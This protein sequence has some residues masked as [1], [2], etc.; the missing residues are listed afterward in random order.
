ML[1]WAILHRIERLFRFRIIYLFYII[2]PSVTVNRIAK[3]VTTKNQSW[4]TI[5]KHYYD[6]VSN[7]IL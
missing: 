1:I 5:K 7:R 3:K 4:N 6:M 2:N